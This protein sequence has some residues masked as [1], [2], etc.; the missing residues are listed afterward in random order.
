MAGRA[1]LEDVELRVRALRQ[2]VEDIERRVE[3]LS[4]QGSSS[5]K[6]IRMIAEMVTALDRRVALLQASGMP[7]SGAAEPSAGGGSGMA[8]GG[9]AEPSA[10][11]GS[12]SGSLSGGA[13][14]TSWN[15]D[16]RPS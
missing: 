2:D 11:S 12:G 13:V 7:S 5:A 1:T 9:A 15:T 14:S 16:D 6:G 3:A 8:S 10:G 4:I